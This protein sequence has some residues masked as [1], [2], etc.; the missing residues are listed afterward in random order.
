MAV[1][2]A[3][4]PEW[5]A[6]WWRRY[7]FCSYLVIIG[8][9]SAGT[10][11]IVR[12]GTESP[13]RYDLLSILGL[14]GLTAWFLAVE[15]RAWLRGAAIGVVVLWAGVSATAHGR[16]WAEYVPTPRVGTKTIIMRTLESRGIRYAS[17]D[18]WIAYYVTFLSNERIIV[19]SDD[20]VRIQQYNREVAA[21]REEAVRLSRRVCQDGSPIAPGVYLCPYR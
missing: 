2:I 6:S 15:R 10:Y 3:M 12:C 14:V 7:G 17:A 4:S 11:V 16:I 9:L 8:G 5:S 21:H 20:F 19:A 18:Y 1:R 13:L